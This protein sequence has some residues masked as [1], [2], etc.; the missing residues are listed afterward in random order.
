[1]AAALLEV[2]EVYVMESLFTHTYIYIL[3][4]IN[5]YIYNIYIYIFNIYIYIQ[6]MIHTIMYV[7]VYIYIYIHNVQYITFVLGTILYIP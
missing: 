6:Y 4:N 2:G 3:Y 5:I 7:R 1:M